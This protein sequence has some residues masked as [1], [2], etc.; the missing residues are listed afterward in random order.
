MIMNKSTR[1]LGFFCSLGLL[2]DFLSDT[3]KPQNQATRLF[4][5][6]QQVGDDTIRKQNTHKTQFQKIYRHIYIELF[7]TDI[8]PQDIFTLGHISIRHIYIRTNLHWTYLHQ[9][10][11]TLDKFT[12]DIFTADK[13]TFTLDIFTQDKFTADIFTSINA[14]KGLYEHIGL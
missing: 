3:Y 12:S 9:D 14:W 6:Y 11:F 7:Y 4:R 10:K 5:P 8:F 1:L 13:F 2:C